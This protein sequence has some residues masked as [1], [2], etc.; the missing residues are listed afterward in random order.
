MKNNKMFR[1]VF[2]EK[3]K[4]NIKSILKHQNKEEIKERLKRM[5]NYAVSRHDYYESYRRNYLNISIGIIGFAGILST[6]VLNLI[7]NIS[8]NSLSFFIFG[9]FYLFA[10]GFILIWYYA[11]K[12]SPDYPY[13]LWADTKSYFHKYSLQ[14]VEYIDNM[15]ENKNKKNSRAKNTADNFLKFSLAWLDLLHD[16]EK[17]ILEDLEQVYILF[18][19]QDYKRKFTK[20]MAKALSFGIS[21][22]SF[23]FLIGL[24]LSFINS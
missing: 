4:K 12:T 16:E 21:I 20:E 19:L 9:I 22:A 14:K 23:S 2:E 8:I 24:I 5:I 15:F 3:I 10:T 1:E 6:L 7:K 17:I 18:L 13:R 11:R